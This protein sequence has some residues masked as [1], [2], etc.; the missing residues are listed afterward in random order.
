MC[1]LSLSLM[2][3]RLH[4][5]GETKSEDVIMKSNRPVVLVEDTVG[6]RFMYTPLRPICST[7]STT[8]DP[9]TGLAQ[10][11]ITS[12]I[13]KMVRTSST[14]HF[15]AEATFRY[16]R[17]PCKLTSQQECTLKGL[18]QLIVT[19]VGSCGPSTETST[20]STCQVVWHLTGSSYKRMTSLCSHSLALLMST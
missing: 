10:G 18:L 7:A 16:Q 3:E 1:K 9:I 6:G 11:T 12:S 17:L 13:L 15:R 19:K 4:L 2:T 8:V 5:S 20:L 14:L